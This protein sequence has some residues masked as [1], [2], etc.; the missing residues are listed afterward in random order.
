MP[1]GVVLLGPERVPH[2]EDALEDT[3][4]DLLIELRAL[5]QI[6]MAVE[7][8]HSEDVGPALGGGA[9]D[10]GRADLGEVLSH[11]ELPI[12]REQGRHNAEGGDLRRMSKAVRGV[13]EEDVEARFEHLLFS[14]KGPTSVTGASTVMLGFRTSTPIGERSSATTSPSMRSTDSFCRP[15]SRCSSGPSSRMTWAWPL[16]SRM[17]RKLKSGKLRMVCIHPSISTRLPTNAGSSAVSVRLIGPS[18]KGPAEMDERRWRLHLPR[19]Y[20]FQGTGCFDL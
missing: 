2:L 20:H 17:T 19:V 7:V 1:G 6:G 11:K 10:F 3:D 12:G 5:G 16:R 14:S 13:I 18:R 15:R 9:D 4:H 8:L